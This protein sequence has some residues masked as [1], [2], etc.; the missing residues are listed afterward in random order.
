MSKSSLLISIILIF[1]ISSFCFA[2][3]NDRVFTRRLVWSTDEHVWRYAVEVDKAVNGI[4]GSLLRDFTSTSNLLINITAGEYRFRIIPHD[5]LDRPGEET[6]WMYFDVRL[7][8]VRQT[9]EESAQ[10]QDIN[11][12][13]ASA[14]GQVPLTPIEMINIK[15]GTFNMGSP[16]GE[17]FRN[18]DETQHSVTLKAFFISKFNVTQKEYLE[19][20]GSNPSYFVGFLNRPVEQV[21]WF[22]AIEYCNKRSQREGLAQVYTITNNDGNKIVTLNSAANG[23]RLPTEAEWEYACRAGTN[24]MYNTGININSNILAS[25]RERLLRTGWFSANS[26]NSTHSIGQKTPNSWGLYDMCGN[27]YE[28][29]WDWYDQ[30]LSRAQSN[31]LGASSGTKRVIRGGSW[32]SGHGEMRSACR[33]SFEPAERHNAIGF[34]VVLDVLTASQT[35]ATASAT[36]IQAQP[37]S[38]RQAVQIISNEASWVRYV[39]GG[40]Q[41]VISG[42]SADFSI[43]KEN[44][45]GQE[46]NVLT[47]TVNLARSTNQWRCGQFMPIVVS[48][49]QRFREG[50]GVRFKVLGDGGRNWFLYIQTSDVQRIGDNSWHRAPINS[51][52][53]RLV[54]INI[55]YSSLKQPVWAQRA[56]KFD[57]NNI[58]NFVIERFAGNDENVSGTSTIKIFDFEIY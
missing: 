22:D 3:D 24:N 51:R 8:V 50:T 54:E 39:Q 29:C 10:I 30:Y 6:Q 17:N 42:T 1:I 21:S 52:N 9:Q 48:I 44:I 11:I 41:T 18:N 56:V 43:N 45:Q 57:K 49:F 27:V 32:R 53:G 25:E 23:Y 34:R 33:G 5:I 7:P 14:I 58:I 38:A 36:V 31:P 13:N 2:Q 40:N 20:M 12:G 28:W 4:F 15:S 37:E 16:A 35:T 19:V 26:D 47:L 55:P 46:K